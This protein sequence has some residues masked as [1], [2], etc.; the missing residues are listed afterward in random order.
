MT[1]TKSPKVEPIQ[2]TEYTAKQSKYEVAG[3]LPLRYIYY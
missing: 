1:T 2:V 3:K